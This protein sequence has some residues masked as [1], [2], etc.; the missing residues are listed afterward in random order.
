MYIFIYICL[1]FVFP[2]ILDVCKPSSVGFSV[3]GVCASTT[4]WFSEFINPLNIII[5]RKSTAFFLQKEL[6]RK[7][8]FKVV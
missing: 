2:K 3:F 5:S 1:S 8:S 6:E 7:V 4:T